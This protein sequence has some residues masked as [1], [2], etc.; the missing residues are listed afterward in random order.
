MEIDK[1]VLVIELL[2]EVCSRDGIS[3]IRYIGK[4]FLQISDIDIGTL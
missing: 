3:D 1:N 2:G 4:S